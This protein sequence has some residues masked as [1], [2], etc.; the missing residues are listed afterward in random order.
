MVLTERELI[1]YQ[2]YPPHNINTDFTKLFPINSIGGHTIAQ[3]N[4]RLSLSVIA[5][6][7]NGIKSVQT[8][9]STNTE[10]VLEWF[11]QLVALWRCT[12]GV[13]RPRSL[14]TGVSLSER[15]RTMISC[16]VYNKQPNQYNTNGTESHMGNSGSSMF[17]NSS[18]MSASSGGASGIPSIVMVPGAGRL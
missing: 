2:I 12:Y 4:S 11:V 8:I 9:D 6:D 17:A 15:L 14:P 10:T 5:S 7:Q 16:G 3:A 18:A 1:C 13:P